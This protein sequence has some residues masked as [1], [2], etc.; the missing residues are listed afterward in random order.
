MLEYP[1]ILTGDEQHQILQLRDYL[2]RLVRSLDNRLQDIEEQG[3][4]T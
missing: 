1:P 4:K 3:E 2:L